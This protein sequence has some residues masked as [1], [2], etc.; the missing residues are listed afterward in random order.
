M[1]ERESPN[2]APAGGRQF[3]AEETLE[4]ESDR[5]RRVVAAFL[6]GAEARPDRAVLRP[7]HGLV[8][9][10]G[11]TAAIVVLVGVIGVASATLAANSAARPTP[12]AS[13]TVPSPTPSLG[14]TVKPS[15]SLS[16]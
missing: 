9:G 10:I 5:W 15:V 8:G 3:T 11:L 16:R 13:A 1:S 2:A 14:T 6:L 12:T 4:I 7:W